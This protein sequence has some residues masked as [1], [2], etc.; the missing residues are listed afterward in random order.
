MARGFYLYGSNPDALANQQ[1]GYDQF[2]TR[3]AEGNRAA[4]ADAE[5]FNIQAFLQAQAADEAARE[6]DNVMR[7]NLVQNDLSRKAAAEQTGFARMIDARNFAAQEA[8]RKRQDEINAPIIAAQTELMKAQAKAANENTG[9]KMGHELAS[10]AAQ[11]GLIFSPKD[12]EQKFGLP[13][14]I[15]SLYFEQA[16]DVQNAIDAQDSELA[17]AAKI[18]TAYNQ[19]KRQL[20]EVT[21]KPID[22]DFWETGTPNADARNA[23]VAKITET[24]KLLQPRVDYLQNNRRQD[25]LNQLQID[26]ETGT[27]VPIL[28]QRPWRSGGKTATSGGGGSSFF[29]GQNPA[30]TTTATES[31]RA[32]K[33]YVLV[34]GEL[35][36]QK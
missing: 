27:Y 3:T 30:A 17:S 18:M 1:F 8:N 7:A 10:R 9:L 31:N 19:A 12:A 26:P 6:R 2:F 11:Q 14:Q 32:V 28:P 15:A 13:T 36:L 23:E 35:Q 4:M 33:K 21:A 22:S 16:K 25:I 24:I 29:Q 34:N 5:R 20:A